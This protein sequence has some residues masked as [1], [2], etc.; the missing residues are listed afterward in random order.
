VEVQGQPTPQCRTQNFARRWYGGHRC[1]TAGLGCRAV[2]T[3]VCVVEGCNVDVCSHVSR[4]V[5]PGSAC[6]ATPPPH[7]LRR[8]ARRVDSA[9]DV[10]VCRIFCGGGFPPRVH[11]QR[12]RVHW[13]GS[14][15]VRTK[16]GGER[17]NE[18]RR[19]QERIVVEYLPRMEAAREGCCC[20]CSCEWQRGLS[21]FQ[22]R[23]SA[24]TYV[25][26]CLCA[27]CSRV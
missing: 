27:R 1:A 15:Q 6:A 12:A 19:G 5:W 13:P 7:A 23:L 16:R 25:H 10:V 22:E 3:Q 11:G 9:R 21:A 20:V 24:D 8:V 18:M 26:A 17:R 2:M 14:E 4:A